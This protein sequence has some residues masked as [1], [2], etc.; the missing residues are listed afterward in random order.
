MKI[1]SLHIKRGAKQQKL[2]HILNTVI[3]RTHRVYSALII[4]PD[5][6]KVEFTKFDPYYGKMGQTIW[7]I[8]TIDRFCRGTNY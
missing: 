2:F 5:F 6:V 8:D 3:C 7:V 1:L 4:V